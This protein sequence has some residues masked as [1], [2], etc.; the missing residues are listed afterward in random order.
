MPYGYY[1]LKERKTI[2]GY[3]LDTKK[4]LITLGGGDWGET[5]AR[6][7]DVSKYITFD[8]DQKELISTADIPNK[9]TVYP[10]KAEGMIANFKFKI[11]PNKEI[12]PGD[13]FTIDFS[14]NID[15]DGIFKDNDNKGKN[16]DSQFDI[17]GPAGKLAEAKI[18]SDRTS[19]TYTFTKYVGDYRPDFMSIF[20]QI[21]PNRRVVDHTQDITVDVNIGDNTDKTN[22]NYHYSDS[23]NINYRGYNAEEE[24][25]GYQNPD[26]AIS[27]YMLRLDPDQKT[28]T[29]ILYLNPWNSNIWNKSLSFT[30]DKYIKI[31]E[32]LS[33]KT[34]VKTGSGSHKTVNNATQEW[35]NGDLPDSYDINE[36]DLQLVSDSK[37][38]YDV[39][40]R[41]VHSFVAS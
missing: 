35:Q 36:D 19:I 14:D 11:D 33:V 23:I 17:I 18:N 1:W 38:D 28:F 5:P 7:E 25:D 2:N 24:Y 20:M 9:T 41:R 3:I 31:N 10:N 26:T 32:N 39:Y 30:T 13:Y 21:F 12:R 15:L 16:P 4:K 27:S 8:G 6:K 22:A 29:A 34:Y 37:Y 40:A